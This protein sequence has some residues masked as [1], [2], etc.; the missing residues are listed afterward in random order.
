MDRKEL[1]RYFSNSIMMQVDKDALLYALLMD[2]KDT[3]TE[4]RVNVES[5]RVINNTYLEAFDNAVDAHERNAVVACVRMAEPVRKEEVASK[6]A[7]MRSGKIKI[8]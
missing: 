2:H 4:I 5:Q 8:N 6:A 1:E 7:D 3:I